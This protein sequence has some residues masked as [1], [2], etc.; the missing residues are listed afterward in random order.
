MMGRYHSAQ[1]FLTMSRQPASSLIRF[2]IFE[3]DLEAGELRK[4]GIKI[5][6]QDQPFQVLAALLQRSGYVLTR[7]ELQERLWA[8]DTFVDFDRAVN[9]AVNRIRAALGDLASTPR[10]IETL[11]R[12]GYRFIAP[13]DDGQS[14]AR[15]RGHTGV[16]QRLVRS[17]LLPPLNTSFLP[18]HFALSPDGTR[19]TFVAADLDGKEGLWVRDLS[20]AGAQQLKGAEGARL[21][22]WSP[23]SRRIG[24]FAEGKL[25]TIDITGGARRIL[26][27]ARAALGGA[28]HSDDIIVFAGHVTGPLH[29]VA[30][31]G[32]IPVPVTPVPGP[33]SS[34]LHCWPVFLPGSDQFLYFVNRTGPGDALCNGI[35]AGS[36][37]STEARL[38]SAEIDGNV[39]FACGHVLFVNAGALKAQSFD[40]ERLQLTDQPVAIV[41]HELE[42]WER[43]WFHSGFSV[44]ETGI[45]VFQSS[46]DFAS[47]LVW[48]DASGNEHGRIRQ[49]GYREPAVSPDGRLVAVSSDNLHDDRW[50]IC[51]HDIERGVTTRLTDGGDDWHPSWSPDGKKIVYAST[52]GHMSSI[53][54]IAA[55]ASGGSQS[56]LERGSMIAHSSP[57]GPMVYM[58]IDRGQVS[59]AVYT[60]HDGETRSLGPGAEPQFS[61]DGKWIAYTE[62][63]GAGISVRQFPGPGPRI[64]ISIGPGAQA[65]WSRDGA[66]LFYIAADKKLMA[67]S[68][69]A[70]SGRAGAPRQLFQT[71]IIAASLVGF[72]Y[73]V[74]PDGRFLI[75]SLPSSSSPLTLLTGWAA[76]LER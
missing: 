44:T 7:E 54:E 24:F 65:R 2:G 14:R 41:Q 3:V 29:R 51:I 52:E 60:P 73:D 26:C 20:A 32:G 23:D 22:F 50:H 70:E 72:Q 25:K 61:P 59:L 75:N 69:D 48:T 67:V 58:R 63:G 55:D 56:L 45:L 6:L 38:I 35:H 74:A 36:L 31:S 9:K 10:F 34:Q 13:I 62:V 40:P 19:L 47:E 76:A 5:K 46:T 11:P 49:R 17:S 1:K 39:G 68:F 12:R 30:A 71:R 33:H 66:Q 15:S 21:P 53:Y 57:D 28:W 4:R 8:A 27:D 64:Q 18:N 16:T 37:R 43:A 42:V